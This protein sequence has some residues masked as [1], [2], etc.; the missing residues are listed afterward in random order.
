M[1]RHWLTAAVVVAGWVGAS[2]TGT[3]A[4]TPPGG[5]A[6]PG[7]VV[8][9]LPAS[10]ATVNVVPVSLADYRIEVPAEIPAGPTRFVATN[11]GREEHHM[12]L[13]RL[14]EGQTFAALIADLVADPV[15]ALG[16]YELVPGPQSVGPGG[17]QA[18]DVDLQPGAYVALCVIPDAAGVPHAAK[19]MITQF[20]VTGSPAAAT[21]VPD[22]PAIHLEEYRFVADP[23]LT[24]GRVVRVENVGGASHEIAFYRVDDGAT[25]DQVIA[26]M[27]NP[28]GAPALPRGTPSGGVTAMSPKHAAGLVLTLRPGAYVAVCFLPTSDKSDHLHKGML[29]SVTVA[30]DGALTLEMVPTG[31]ATSAPGDTTP[32]GSTPMAPMPVGTGPTMHT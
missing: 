12:T 1:N 15:V 6:N 7:T 9:D 27:L 29:A 31:A 23:G 21:A 24:T 4:T 5:S 19:G 28:A 14:A 8:T 26:A 20:T 2:A 32:G 16:K 30:A 17:T 3:A 13:V 10:A 11:V 25:V 22:G 18:I